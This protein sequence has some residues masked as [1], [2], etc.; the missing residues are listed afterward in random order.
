MPAGRCLLAL[1]RTCS[2]RTAPHVSQKMLTSV[3][4]ATAESRAAHLPA[5]RFLR[6][7]NASPRVSGFR[8]DPVVL[9]ALES[10]GIVSKKNAA[11]Q[12]CNAVDEAEGQV[13]KH[14]SGSRLRS[15][16][17]RSLE[18]LRRPDPR[19]A[20]RLVA[21]QSPRGGRQPF[22]DLHARR[23]VAVG[24]VSPHPRH[25]VRR[26]GGADAQPGSSRGP[27]GRF[28]HGRDGAGLRR[29]LCAVRSSARRAD[30]S[31]RHIIAVGEPGG[32]ARDVLYGV[33][34]WGTART[35]WCAGRRREWESLSRNSSEPSIPH[36]ASPARRAARTRA[37]VF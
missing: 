8:H 11:L 3:L 17:T 9:T 34:L 21:D 19:G 29:R 4:R 37:N 16:R 31:R 20:S 32:R 14:E 5:Q 30:P 24:G 25:R 2:P 36:A 10:R 33:R 22:R 13:G 6:R 23:K 12:S 15:G 7:A 1:M 35:C 26:A 28:H 27:N 18:V